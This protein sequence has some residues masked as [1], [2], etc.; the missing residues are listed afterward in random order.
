MKIA[1]GDWFIGRSEA[2]RILVEKF[3]EHKVATKQGFSR[4]KSKHYY[5]DRRFNE[6]HA[7]VKELEGLLETLQEVPIKI[8]KKKK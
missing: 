6:L 5:Y 1:I 8:N 4:V 2:F 3:K 7:R